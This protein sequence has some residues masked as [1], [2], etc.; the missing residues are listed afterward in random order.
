M[1]ALFL[2]TRHHVIKECPRHSQYRYIIEEVDEYV[3]EP[4]WT[5]DHLGEPKVMLPGFIEY[6][7]ALGVS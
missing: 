7:K 5:I 1:G 2:H 3:T 6:L 4:E